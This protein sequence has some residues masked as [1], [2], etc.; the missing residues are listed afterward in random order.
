MKI[1]IFKNENPRKFCITPIHCLPAVTWLA[2]WSA[3]FDVIGP[4]LLNYYGNQIKPYLLICWCVYYGC[5]TILVYQKWQVRH[6]EELHYTWHGGCVC[7]AC[8]SGLYLV[9]WQG[10]PYSE[11]TQEDVDLIRHFFPQAVDEYT[12]RQ[13]SSFLPSKSCKVSSASPC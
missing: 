8:T 7:S 10:L 9:K 4:S 13:K 1:F 3:Q 12:V 11:C 2:E 6:P 5:N